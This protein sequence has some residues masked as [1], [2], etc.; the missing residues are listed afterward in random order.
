MATTPV[1]STS[2]NP[3]A[4]LVSRLTQKYDKNGDSQLSN[5]EFG[6]FL[7]DF[8]TNSG[9]NSTFA[10]GTA[11]RTS[12]AGLTLGTMEGFD[13][14]KLANTS[15]NTIKYQVGR[16]LQQYP[17]TPQGLRDAL[18]AIQQIVPGAQIIGTN[19]DKIDFGGFIDAKG[20]RIGIVDV[21]RGAGLGGQA[22]QWLAD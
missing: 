9:T 15:H 12:G 4:D 6:T 1:S 17:N 7:N 14:T 16:V 3:I 8:L 13:P 22:W 20:D 11:A 5:T 2:S 10:T 19:G 18:P 21:L